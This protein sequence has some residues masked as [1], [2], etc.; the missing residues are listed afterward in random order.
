MEEIFLKKLKKVKWIGVSIAIIYFAIKTL[1][2]K[3]LGFNEYLCLSLI[4]VNLFENKIIIGSIVIIYAI[5]KIIYFKELSFAEC[6]CLILIFILTSK[7]KKYKN[8]GISDFKKA[9][10]NM[11][12]SKENTIDFSKEYAIFL[13]API[14]S[15]EIFLSFLEKIFNYREYLLLELLMAF[16]FVIFMIIFSIKSYRYLINNDYII[17]H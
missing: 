12:L 3:E 6:I 4:F 10:F 14:F 15:G 8:N 5:V 13:L 9:P 7:G 11:V 17:E 2:F 1:Y 16:F